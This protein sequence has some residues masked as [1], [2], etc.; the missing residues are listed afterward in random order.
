M[1]LKGNNYFYIYCFFILKINVTFL[2]FSSKCYPSLVHP[3]KCIYSMHPP[4]VIVCNQYLLWWVAI[5]PHNATS[6]FGCEWVDKVTISQLSTDYTSVTYTGNTLKP[7][8]TIPLSLSFC[9]RNTVF[10]FWIYQFVFKLC[11]RIVC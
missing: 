2:Y 5:S 9:T 4:C 11:A 7:H 6:A 8:F 1:W 10:S 3:L